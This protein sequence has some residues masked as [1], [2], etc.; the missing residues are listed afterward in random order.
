MDDVRLKRL[1]D[2]F[3]VLIIMDAELDRLTEIQRE[4]AH[5]RLRINHITTRHKVEVGIKVK[6]VV[7]YQQRI[8]D[9]LLQSYRHLLN[10]ARKFQITRF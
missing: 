10:F 7:G 3:R 2:F 5:D 1:Q 8:V 4:D 9:Q 6:Q